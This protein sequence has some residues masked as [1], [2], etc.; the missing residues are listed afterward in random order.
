MLLSFIVH[1][2]SLRY[3]LP[4]TVMLG[5][6]PAYVLSW[7]V[8]RLLS[9]VLPARLYHKLDD[10]L[11]CI[12]QSMVLFFFE[13]YTGVEIIIYG[14]IPKNKENVIYVSNHQCTADW[15]I[16]D[17]LAIRQSAIGHVRYVLKDGLK[18]LPL[19]GWYFS[20]H[21]GVYVKRSAKFNEKAMVKKLLN[22]TECGAPMYLVI[23]PEGTRYNPEL[24]NVIADSQA[25]AAKEGLGV[26]SHTLT[27]RMKASHI[28]LQ[29]MRG[30][31]DAVYDI[32]VAYEGSLD[33][34][35]QRKPAPSMPEFLCKECP[36]VH[37]HFER[38]DVK[39]IPAEPVFFRRWLHERFEIKDR[40]LKNFY[41]SED[42]DKLT[43][44][45]GEGR[46]SPLSLCKTLPSLLVLGGLTVSLLLTESG[47]KVYARTWVYGTLLGWL[48]VN[49]SP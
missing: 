28:A 17:M 32:T 19:Y 22:Q 23:F 7:G 44:F 10:R 1:T 36:R 4:A 15:I 48:W 34:S 46:V 47:R 16:A 38:V 40:L 24:K 8:W 39:E 49:V 43:K 30:H 27:P 14:E 35:R 5:T 45:P 26:L 13:H 29:T 37:I 21:G 3:W 20:Q 41:E 25:F 9:S 31:L 6:A 12:Y 33:A 11:Y 2:H 42:A 18:W